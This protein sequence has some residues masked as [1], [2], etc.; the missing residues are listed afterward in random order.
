MGKLRTWRVT[1]TVVVDVEAH[2]LDEARDRAWDAVL[3]DD[4]DL[5]DDGFIES[6][7]DLG[8]TCG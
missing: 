5:R 3:G 4:A 7:E 1:F 6:V 8:V 2:D